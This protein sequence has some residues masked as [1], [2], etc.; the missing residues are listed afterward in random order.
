[1]RRLGLKIFVF[2]LL[3]VAVVTFILERFGGYI[4]YFYVKVTTPVQT[5]LILGDS[6]PMQ[7]I[8][9]SIINECMPNSGFE[10]PMYNFAFTGVQGLYGPPYFK[11]I[12]K[13]LDPNTKNGLFIIGVSPAQLS[14]SPD[15][16]ERNHIFS[17]ANQPPHNMK[18]INMRPNFEYF[19][20]NYRFFHFN[21]LFRGKSQ[22][23]TDGWLEQNVFFSPSERAFK[24]KQRIQGVVE[25]FKNLK[26]STYRL[27]SLDSLI[28]FLSRRGK[29][30]LV[31]L[32]MDAE[33]VAIEDRYWPQFNSKMSELAVANGIKYFNFTQKNT[34]DMY[35]GAHLGNKSGALFTR[36]LCDSIRKSLPNPNQN[37]NVHAQ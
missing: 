25:N 9:P 37:K 2:A 21:A 7:G 35:D 11:S 17:E 20:R 34:F 18:F 6:R 14:V 15:D 32:P 13:K 26:P 33:P 4:D 29:V 23:H 16:D 19:F 5:S 3:V 28:S 1:M 10:L 8:Q 31:R 24:K 22:T 30:V 36:V 27:Q 12:R